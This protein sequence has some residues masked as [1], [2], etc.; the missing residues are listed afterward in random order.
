MTM[1]V[2]YL[3]HVQFCADSCSKNIKPN[4]KHFLALEVSGLISHSAD[5]KFTFVL[6]C[7]EILQF[8]SD[9]KRITTTM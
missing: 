7:S 1:K 2:C 4:C 8:K 6:C 5:L 3:F 9:R